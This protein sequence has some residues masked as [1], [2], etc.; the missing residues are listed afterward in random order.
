LLA[1]QLSGKS[2]KVSDLAVVIANA[3]SQTHPGGKVVT[4]VLVFCLP[5]GL[6]RY[7]HYMIWL[8]GTNRKLA[9][10]IQAAFEF[11]RVSAW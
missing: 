5:F 2:N 10:Y 1:A 4:T 7:G 3:H 9:T 11:A 8:V 6:L